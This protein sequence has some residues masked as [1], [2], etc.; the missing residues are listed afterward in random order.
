MS[1]WELMDVA[2]G[3]GSC[4][5][6]KLWTARYLP[7]FEVFGNKGQRGGLERA[8]GPLQ[9]APREWADVTASFK[10]TIDDVTIYI[11]EAN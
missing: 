8:Q 10:L 3:E 4:G 2:L 1:M 5:W 9:F 11:M 6:E 7:G